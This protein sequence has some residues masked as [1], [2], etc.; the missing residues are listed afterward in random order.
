MT[1]KHFAPNVREEMNHAAFWIQRT[2]N[3]DHVIVHNREACNKIIAQQC[4]RVT[5]ILS[6]P[7]WISG[8]ETRR[9]INRY[10]LPENEARYNAHGEPFPKNEYINIRDNLNT[11]NIAT[12]TQLEFGIPVQKTVVRA[13]PTW[14]RNALAPNNVSFDRFQ[15]TEIDV[16]TPIAIVHKSADGEWFFAKTPLYAGWIPCK[17][18]AVAGDRSNIE[19]LAAPKKFLMTT[20]SSVTANNGSTFQ[21][22][23][24]IPLVERN[25]N[26]SFLIQI[27]KRD[28]HGKLHLENSILQAECDV[29][30]GFLSYTTRNLFQQIFKMQGEPYSWG[31]RESGRDCTRLII[32][33]LA[34]FGIQIPRNSGD[35]KNMGT[36]CLKR[37]KKIE[38]DAIFDPAIENLLPGTF[39]Y[40]DGHAMT[41]LGTESGHHYIMHAFSGYQ[42]IASS[43]G[44]PLFGAHVT[45]L[46]IIRGG[47]A[48]IEN[49]RTLANA[50][51]N[52]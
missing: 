31:G 10:V 15:E 12:K 35:Q 25:A 8:P 46:A 2:P 51:C 23:T 40:S 4:Q 49:A 9:L 42:H 30:E 14:E 50:G 11:H 36:E 44:T 6:E 38:V 19:P 13:F 27:P 1:H 32:D 7:E 47:I 41:Y 45:N 39:L 5:N 43:L 17:D 28:V 48:A 33:T 24:K 26:G 16:F 18:I 37:E 34:T 3:P 22:G 20:G 52:Q 21:M 29:H